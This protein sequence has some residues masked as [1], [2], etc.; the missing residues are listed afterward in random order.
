MK[1]DGRATYT[2]KSFDH[3]RGLAGLSDAQVTEHLDL[4]AGYVKQVNALVQ[5]L[6]EMRADRGESGK[7]FSLAEGTRRLAYE[8]NGM[9]LHELYFSNLKPG[10]EARP[11]DRQALGRAL[12]ESFGSVDHWQENFQAIGGMRG[13]GWVILYEDPVNGRLMNQWISLHQD[14]MPARWKPILVMDVWEHAFMRDYKAS[15]RAKYVEAFF[16]NIDWTAV[17]GRLR[18]TSP[19]R[20]TAA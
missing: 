6:S 19:A 12:A 2:A 13:I 10:R 9:V 1:K 5:E 20:A 11:A 18:E 14:G 4:Y 3:L 8:Y 17:D 16:K 7:D 15:E